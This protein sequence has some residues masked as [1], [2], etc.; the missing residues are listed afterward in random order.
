MKNLLKYIVVASLVVLVSSCEDTDKQRIPS[1][2]QDGPNVRITVDPNFGF[3]NFEELET[4]YIQY[5]IFSNGVGFQ[6]AELEMI[7]VTGGV[8]ID[9]AVVKTYGPGDFGS[10]SI[11]QERLT[12]VEL[13]AAIGLTIDDISGGDSFVF[14][15]RVTMNADPDGTVRV[16]PDVTL[17]GNLNV[18]PTMVAAAGTTSYTV[19]FTAYAGC[20]SNPADFVGNYTA[21]ITASNYG[22]FIGSTNP[23]VDINFVGP[24]PFRY[25][26]GDVSALAY[27]PFG[28]EAYPGDFYDICGAPLG[29]PTSTF[30]STTD[31]G[32]STWDVDTKTLTMNYFES[33]NG[34]SWTV[35]Y[36]PNP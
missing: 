8:N 15:N 7:Y 16:Y 31:T 10:G 34:L 11:R 35:V 24:E 29:L 2:F 12:A 1:D 28:G 36:T 33:F 23:D 3:L 9:T 18:S 20:P 26:I 21:T 30:G 4:T 22:G 25:Q 17:G 19:G 5:D 6:T 32:G 14:T 13:M 27:V